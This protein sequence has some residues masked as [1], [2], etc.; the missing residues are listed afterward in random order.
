MQWSM[1]YPYYLIIMA[2]ATLLIGIL[3]MKYPRSSGRRYFTVIMFL[4]FWLMLLTA[5]ELLS[6]SFEVMLWL[7]NFQQ[8]AI[9]FGALFLFALARDYVGKEIVQTVRLVK[10]FSIPIFVYLVLVF[11]DQIHHLMRTDVGIQQ[12]GSI[13]E[14]STQP[15]FLNVIFMAY[16]QLLALM[17]VLL[18]LTN[19]KNFSNHQRGRHLLF[20]VGTSI[21]VLAPLILPFLPIPFPGRLAVS[22]TIAGFI[23]FFV[24]FRYEFLSVFPIAKDRIF[25][26]MSEGI[27][28][29]DRF[30]RITDINPA[31]ERILKLLE[32]DNNT[33]MM[34]AFVPIF[35]NNYDDL[36]VKFYQKE[37]KQGE[38]QVKD[39]G[40]VFSFQVRFLP[41]ET[42]AG[43][44]DGLLLIFTDITDKKKYEN[45]LVRKATIDYLTGLY[46]RMHFL[47]VFYEQT[48]NYK[49]ISAFLL[50]DIDSFKK[51]NDTFG[52]QVGD[53]VLIH[54]SEKMREA[55]VNEGIFGRIGGEEFTIFIK[56]KSLRDTMALAERFRQEVERTPM[57][58]ESG[59]NITVNVSIGVAFSSRGDISFEIFHKYADDALYLA[60]KSGKNQV[61]AHEIDEDIYWDESNIAATQLTEEGR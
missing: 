19:M 41:I 35:F 46:N 8:P 50:L 56:G 60:K 14:I 58:L 21:P 20:L 4:A 48:A 7:R 22:F 52:H 29:I 32:T 45:E 30:D 53:K 61:I 33:M 31:G 42:S 5:A 10:L 59:E 39:Q 16:Y 6:S 36:L 49:G 54:F 51:I 43:R 34:G 12:Y 1:S 27:V 3:T 25:E 15:T 57:T 17:A 37:E 44:E 26:Q 47:D 9:F 38:F 40:Q 11:T 28:V 13:T 55:F 24:F 2:F 18:L 23:I